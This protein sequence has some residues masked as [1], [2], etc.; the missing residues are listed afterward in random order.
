VA[1]IHQC[2]LADGEE[3]DRV[4]KAVLAHTQRLATRLRRAGI[5]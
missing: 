2:H 3:L 5:R 1:L 4:A